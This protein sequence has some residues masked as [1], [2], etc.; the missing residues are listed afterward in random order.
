MKLKKGYQDLLK[1][2]EAAIETVSVEQAKTMLD[3]PDVQLIDI[4]DPRELERDG[5][6]PGAVHCP[7]GMLE[8][9]IDPECKYYKEVFGTGK[10]FVFFC[11]SGWR[12]ALATKTVQ[13]M[14]LEPVCHIEGGF[15]AWKKAG[16]PVETE[17]PWKDE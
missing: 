9:W 17:G 14:G 3:D 16:G 10:T 1:E 2:A 7:R 13:D 4:R 8:F 5:R 12:S 6:I 11:R 15:G